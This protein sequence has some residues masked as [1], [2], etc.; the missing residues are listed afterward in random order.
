M[1][2]KIVL[3]AVAVVIAALGATMLALYVNGASTKASAK[4][5]LVKVLTATG[6]INIGET[7]TQAQS[8]GKLALTEVPKSSV[9]SGAVS[10][11]DTMGDEVALAP[12][13]PGEQILGVKFGT[14][15]AASAETL[16]VP[17]G[18]VAVSV[19]LS[20]PGR[21]AGFVTPGAQVAI[22]VSF[23]NTGD[24]SLPASF[25]RILVNKV[26][27]IGVG[28]TTILSP[29]SDTTASAAGVVP[30]TIL[31]VALSQRDSDRVIYAS[32]NDALAFGLLGRGTQITP[33]SGVTQQDLLK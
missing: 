11:I 4:E 29:P 18:K 19:Q 26:Q 10:S 28:P 30:Q 22:F 2:R 13:Y 32:T 7:A 24:P 16:P 31:T 21:V 3:L 17:K 23:Q 5:S 27:V 15:A 12:I 9:L 6:V 1:K 25:T 8:E 20:D 14:S 33:D